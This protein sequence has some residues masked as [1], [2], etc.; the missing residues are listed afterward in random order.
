MFWDTM[1]CTERHKDLS[2]GVREDMGM[3][4]DITERVRDIIGNNE[5]DWAMVGRFR[6]ILAKVWY[7]VG[8][9]S[10]QHGVPKHLK[11][12]YLQ[13]LD[14]TKTEKLLI[15]A[16]FLMRRILVTK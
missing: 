14:L 11:G 9:G 15:L 1:G 4:W 2:K 12:V 7:S 5:R 3:Y 8:P 6:V 10:V 16:N 13:F